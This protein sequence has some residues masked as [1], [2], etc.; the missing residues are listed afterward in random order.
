M[1]VDASV[2]ELTIKALC[3]TVCRVLF[4][5]YLVDAIPRQGFLPWHIDPALVDN[6]DLNAR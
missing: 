1:I 3:L 6:D 2:T 5:F 4:D